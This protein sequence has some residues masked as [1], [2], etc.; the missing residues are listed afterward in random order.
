MKT[1]CRTILNCVKAAGT[2]VQ[3]VD[4][5]AVCTC[6]GLRSTSLCGVSAVPAELAHWLG[7]VSVAGA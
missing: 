3:D 7:F 5:L 2:T 1:G 6:T 4:F